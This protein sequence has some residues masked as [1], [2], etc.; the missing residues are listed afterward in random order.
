MQGGGA[1]GHQR[2][3]GAE[4]GGD[5]AAG[6]GQLLTPGGV[7]AVRG[8]G[9]VGL[10]GLGGGFGGVLGSGLGTLLRALLGGG[11]GGISAGGPGGAGA[12][13]F[14]SMSG[15]PGGGGYP[16]GYAG[17]ADARAPAA[18]AG[19]LSAGTSAGSVT[20]VCAK[21]RRS[22]D[23]STTSRSVRPNRS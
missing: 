3:G 17:T 6:P 13:R 22:A 2:D 7:V 14:G 11:L 23:Q 18:G 21:A 16:D 19:V 9:L 10:V 20:E 5:R 4:E 1:R 8:G 15:G 12:S